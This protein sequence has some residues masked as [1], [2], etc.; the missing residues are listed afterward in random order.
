MTGEINP[1]ERRLVLRLLDHW[2]AMA[3]EL[4][5]PRPDSV[6]P[7]AMTDMWTFCFMI[8]DARAA[9]RLSYVGDYHKEMYGSDPTGL[10]FADVN[11]DTLIGRSASYL[12][13][14]LAKNVPVTYGGQFVDIHGNGLLYRSILLPLST[15]GK[16][17]NAVLGGANCR[18]LDLG[19]VVENPLP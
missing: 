17:V 14:V 9:P 4:D 18:I 19:E 3:G 15:D 16:T 8:D 5:W 11:S 2:R 6:E 12:K 7:A 1:R 10:A 13:D